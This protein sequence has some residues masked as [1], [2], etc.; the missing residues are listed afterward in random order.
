MLNNFGVKAR[1]NF[2]HEKSINLIEANIQEEKDRN[3]IILL[4]DSIN[5]DAFEFVEKLNEKKLIG[6]FLVIVTSSNDQKGNYVRSRKL[7]I[8]Y[9]LIE[10]CQ[11]SELFDILQDNFPNVRVAQTG[12]VLKSKLRKEVSILLAEDNLM[13]QKLARSFF[14]NLGYEIDIAENGVEVVKMVDEKDYD[15]IFMDVMMPEMDGWDA[16][17]EVRKKDYNM[18]IVPI[19]ADF[20]EDA[21]ARAKMEGMNDFISKP[22]RIEELKRVLMRWFTESST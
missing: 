9:Y 6:K 10:P 5:F 14:K 12:S 21:K 1:L 2:Y 4:R 22:V 7:G 19:T 17:K 8:D 20:S 18:P 15:I 13:N 16:A 11:G 3:H